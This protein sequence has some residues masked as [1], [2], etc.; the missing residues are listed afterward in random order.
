MTT[1]M[2]IIDLPVHTCTS[3]T[4]IHKQIYPYTKNMIIST[5]VSDKRVCGDQQVLM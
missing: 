2:I 3:N 5:H 4:Y 1:Y